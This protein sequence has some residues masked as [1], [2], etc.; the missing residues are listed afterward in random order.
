MQSSKLSTG[1]SIE[2]RCTKCR[3]NNS[4]LIITTSGTVP[5]IVQCTICNRQH[6]YRPPS[7]IKKPAKSREVQLKEAEHQEW[8]SMQK[9]I[10]STKASAYS[11]TDSYKVKTVINHPIF[12]LGQVQRVIGAQKMEVLFEDGR[13]T[14][15]CK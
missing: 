5:T 6:K 7:A 11:M 12:G 10:N 1:D 13:K 15:R 8:V 3:K 9:T 2:A 14:M 4:H